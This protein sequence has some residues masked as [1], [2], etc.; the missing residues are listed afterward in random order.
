MAVCCGAE[1]A[2][3]LQDSEPGSRSFRVQK[4]VVGI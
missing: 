4:G 3:L 1:R 2:W